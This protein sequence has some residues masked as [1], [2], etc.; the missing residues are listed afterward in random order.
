MPSAIL[1]GDFSAD[2]ENKEICKI[3]LSPRL[4][5][6]SVGDKFTD[7]GKIEFCTKVTVPSDAT[8]FEI[9]GTTL[10]TTLYIG[11]ELSGENIAAP[12][13]FNI[14]KNLW[15]KEIDLKIVQ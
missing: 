13:I 10:Y 2:I 14:D 7:Y 9:T 15:G 11:D 12:Y 1:I 8:K 3:N 6:Y 4:K 5:R